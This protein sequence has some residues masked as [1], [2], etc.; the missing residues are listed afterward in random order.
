MYSTSLI[1][2]QPSKPSLKLEAQTLASCMNCSNIWKNLFSV[3]RCSPG[4]ATAANSDALS[5]TH[6]DHF[7]SSPTHLQMAPWP[8]MM[9]H[10]PSLRQ[11]SVCS[12]Q[13]LWQGR[14]STLKYPAL[15]THSASPDHLFTLHSAY[16]LQAW[17]LQGSAWSPGQE[18]RR[19]VDLKL[20]SRMY[21]YVVI[22]I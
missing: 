21:D 19:T 6:K 2:I 20:M 11:K 16:S 18:N 3:T 17:N 12:S 10:L 8:G 5:R 14:P 22:D 13:M 9:S 4:L 7:P 15:Q 1:S